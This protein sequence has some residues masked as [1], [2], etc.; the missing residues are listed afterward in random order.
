MQNKI[1]LLGSVAFYIF[2]SLILSSILKR[3]F[4][5]LCIFKR[6][7]FIFYIYIFFYF[8]LFFLKEKN[9]NSALESVVCVGQQI[10]KIGREKKICTGGKWEKEKRRQEGGGGEE[11]RKGEGGEREILQQIQ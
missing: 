3:N 8:I 7:I 6:F 10:Q 4:L 9:P 5:Y 2:E 11:E 1:G